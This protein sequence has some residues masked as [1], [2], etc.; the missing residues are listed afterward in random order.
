MRAEVSSAAHALPQVFDDGAKVSEGSSTEED[1]STGDDQGIGDGSEM[2]QGREVRGERVD[3]TRSRSNELRKVF[4]S[5]SGAGTA[6]CII[7]D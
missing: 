4:Q 5:T 1:S 6:V 7:F 3:G 2:R